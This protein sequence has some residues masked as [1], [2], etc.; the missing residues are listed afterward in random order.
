MFRF[1]KSVQQD[2]ASYQG[3]QVQNGQQQISDIMK[4]RGSINNNNIVMQQQQQKQ[5]MNFM[6]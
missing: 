5:M 1:D 6:Q 2:K 3:K 4:P